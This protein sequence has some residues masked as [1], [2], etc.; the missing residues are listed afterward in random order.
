MHLEDEDK[1]VSESY[2]DYPEDTN[3]LLHT[4][5]GDDEHERIGSRIFFI[6]GFTTLGGF[7]FGYDIGVI[8]GVLVMD[9]FRDAMDLARTDEEGG[10]SDSVAS[11]LGSV[12]ALLSLGCFFGSLAAGKFA[13]KYGRKKATFSGGLFA[14]VGGA[15]Q[16]GATGLGMMYA[17]RIITGIGIGILSST[18]PLYNAE[19]APKRIRGMLVSLQQLAITFGIMVAF[20][21]NLGVE[22]TRASW[23]FPMWLQCIASGILVVGSPFLPES[24]RWLVGQRLVA[25]AEACIRQIRPNIPEQKLKS[26]VAEIEKSCEEEN[27]E[28]SQSWLSLFN[29]ENRYRLMLG[30][31]VMC[32]SQFTGINAIIYYSPIIFESVGESA[33]IGTAVIG[34]VN[35]FS[36]FI[37]MYAID[38]AGRKKLLLLGSVGMLVSLLALVVLVV[39]LDLDAMEIANNSTGSLTNTTGTTSP[40]KVG[41]SL[42]VFFL[43]VFVCCFAWSWGP[44]S[45][46]YVS[47]VFAPTNR[48][49]AVGLAT[50]SNWIIN[51]LLAWATPVMLSTDS[52]LGLTGTFSFY[53]VWVVLGFVFVASLCVETKGCS[54]EDIDKFFEPPYAFGIYGYLSRRK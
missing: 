23:R 39:V 34:S 1:L 38:R 8:G 6:C 7:V 51:A 45:W 35:F 17:G 29:K 15:V 27:S 30:M 48:G 9:G 33:F 19:V 16:A 3:A 46:V 26:E 53:S 22:H 4:S 5:G 31:G 52:G 47:E 21:V 18:V 50:A 14:T 54:L 42:T 12:V 13:D 36:T 2:V 43:T 24:P 28:A 11:K 20:L 41:G 37:A 10:N 25:R 49:K 32:F 44:I 40:S